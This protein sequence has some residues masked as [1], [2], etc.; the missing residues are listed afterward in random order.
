M[1]TTTAFHLNDF[2]LVLQIVDAASLTKGA[3]RCHLSLS[4]AS[5]RIKNLEDRLNLKLFQRNAQGVVPTE[6]CQTYVR[7][8]RQILMQ[9][10]LL[11]SDLRPFSAGIRGQ[12]RLH[13]N[14]TAVTEFLP[15]VLGRFLRDNPDI[16]VDL[17]ERESDTIVRSVRDG[18]A[19]IGMVAGSVVTDGLQVRKLTSS[20]LVV[21]APVGHPVLSAP[22]HFKDTLQYPY[23]SLLEA[24]A[25]HSYIHAMASSM[26]ILPT[27]RV[28]VASYDAVCR[29]VASGAGISVIP[30]VVVERLMADADIGYTE[31]LDPWAIRQYQLC[32][33]DF[34]QLPAFSQQLVNAL[35]AL[36]HPT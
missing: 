7:H 13:A 30:L 2:H 31:L 32:A 24:S 15:P 35:M 3:E 28:H 20:K 8:A 27:V 22:L 11:A 23:V 19:D 26:H 17:K 25:W 34:D 29:M 14:T 5:Q 1:T 9:L 12:V 36:Y 6:A 10:D 33:R 4:A 21:V 18:A 16:Q